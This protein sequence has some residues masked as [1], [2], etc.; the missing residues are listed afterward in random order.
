MKNLARTYFWWPN[1]D[2]YIELFVSSCILCVEA[3]PNPP[4]A[5]LINWPDSVGV[6]DRVHID[7]LGP[8]FVKMF[9]ILTDAF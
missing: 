9:F 2:K 1:L 7:Y 6:F 3:R 8:V 4:L 5:R